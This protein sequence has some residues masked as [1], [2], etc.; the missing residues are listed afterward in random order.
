[1]LKGGR[2]DSDCSNICYVIWVQAT[3]N[4]WSYIPDEHCEFP[5]ICWQVLAGH[6]IL[7]S[8]THTYN[9]LCYVYNEYTYILYIYVGILGAY[10]YI[11][12]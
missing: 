12:I 7:N 11:S 5:E 2:D 10:I 1:M 9:M 6:T 3:V 8:K 4:G